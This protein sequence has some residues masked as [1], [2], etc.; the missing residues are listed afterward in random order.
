VTAWRLQ[1]SDGRLREGL[2]ASQWDA[3]GEADHGDD[4]VEVEIEPHTVAILA[5]WILDHD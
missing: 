3:Q 4:A 2:Y 5:P 1:S